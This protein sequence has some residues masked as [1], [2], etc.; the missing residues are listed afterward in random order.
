M[1]FIFGIIVLGLDIWALVN[2]WQSADS[3]VRKLLWTL[4]IVILP[5]IGFIVWFLFG[6]RSDTHAVA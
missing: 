3:V 5:I 4:G 1:E 2:V 6:P